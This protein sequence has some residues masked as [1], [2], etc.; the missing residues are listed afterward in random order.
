MP[1]VL[2]LCPTFDHAETLFA[3]TASV[4]AQRFQ[5]WEL[6]VIGDGAPDH[7]SEILLAISQGDR[8]IR[9]EAHPK[10]ERY[11]EIYRDRVIRESQAEAVLQLGDD[12]LWAPDHIDRML[13]VLGDADWANE[14]PLRVA[15]D[16]SAEWWPINHG[17]ASVRSSLVRGVPVSAG[18]N[19]VAYRREAY[20]QLPEGWTCAPPRGPS[21]AFM[22]AKFFRLPNLRVASTAS[23]TAIKFPSH[24]PG[25]GHFD[26]RRRLAELQPWLAR[27]T[28][29]GL[30][31]KLCTGAS[32]RSRLLDIYEIHAVRADATWREALRQCGFEPTAAHEPPRRAA[33][34]DP[35]IL[36][37]S[38]QQQQEA[39]LSL[40][41][42]RQR[43]DSRAGM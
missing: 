26:S 36:P 11:G 2:I 37:L 39:E 31:G 19:F 7:T 6:V 29:P 22:W 9:Y 27:I 40:Q 28:E 33:N 23:T 32:V 1:R 42:Y 5:D 21:D 25:R 30:V 3:S 12:D 20:L 35:M 17:T 41:D 8:R 43:L 24:V 10:S 13:E 4:R 38:P 18:P 16:G 15:P 14:A 34:G